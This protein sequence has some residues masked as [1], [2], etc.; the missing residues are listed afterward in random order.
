MAT[1]LYACLVTVSLAVGGCTGNPG[2]EMAERCS[3]GLAT[4]NGELRSARVR[5]LGGTA[6]W[7]KAASLLTAAKIQYEFEHYPNCVDKV[8]RARFYLGRLRG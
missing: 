4:A 5:G 7:S 3:R 8:R 6:N 2:G 1:K